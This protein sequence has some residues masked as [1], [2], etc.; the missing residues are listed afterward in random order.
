M[1]KVPD[2]DS[3][4]RGEGSVS[5]PKLANETEKAH[6]KAPEQWPHGN[7]KIQ[8]CT[9][10]GELLVRQMRGSDK[11]AGELFNPPRATAQ[12]NIP[13]DTDASAAYKI[14]RNDKDEENKPT[15]DRALEKVDLTDKWQ[16]DGGSLVMVEWELWKFPVHWQ[17]AFSVAEGAI[18]AIYNVSPAGKAQAY[19]TPEIS[20]W[21]D[22]A[23]VQWR[24][25]CRMYESQTGSPASEIRYIFRCEIVNELTIS[26]I[27]SILD[28]QRNLMDKN[29]SSDK[30]SI[31]DEHQKMVDKSISSE[32]CY[33]V[34]ANTPQGQALLGSPNGAGVAYL[35][36][37]HKD[38][39]GIRT[40]DHI[41][42]FSAYYGED[43]FD[44]NTTYS[45]CFRVS[46]VNDPKAP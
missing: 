46:Q 6:P 21:S 35:L 34:S 8:R 31:L 15:I 17:N 12:A 4:Q 18:F 38:Q 20:H 24:N 44:V 29:I 40:I 2:S 32:N 36:I 41:D 3:N 27:K 9:T 19:L 1:G 11:E 37:Q 14:M 10:K 23:F 5:P 28:E 25:E 33:T 16:K 42:I 26:V 30:R 45:L 7:A 13:E 22:A 43:I 39:L